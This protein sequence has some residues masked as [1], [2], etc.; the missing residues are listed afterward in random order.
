MVN[1]QVFALFRQIKIEVRDTLLKLLGPNFTSES[2][3]KDM[4]VSWVS[5]TEEFQLQ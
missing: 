2:Q 1:N 5:A 3:Q 4:L